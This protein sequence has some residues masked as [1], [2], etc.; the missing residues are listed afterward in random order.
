MHKTNPYYHTSYMLVT[1]SAGAVT[2]RSI[3]DPAMAAA[4][5]RDRPHA[6]DGPA[7]AQQADRQYALLSRWPSTRGTK[8]RRADM[9]RAVADGEMDAALVWGPIAGYQP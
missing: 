2:A 1:R 3:G 7:A 5:R 8:A 6:A 4:A 9:L